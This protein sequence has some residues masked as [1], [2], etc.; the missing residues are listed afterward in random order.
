METEI[1]LPN[2]FYGATVLLIPKPHKDP[3]KKEYFRQ[4]SLRNIYAKLL[5]K[6]LAN[7]IQEHI[8]TIIHHDQI[9]FIPGMRD[10]S[11]YGDPS[12]QSTI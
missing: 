10:G 1:T 12:T 4:I 8:K 7:R 6:I 11:I 5:N 9:D 2:S 3:R